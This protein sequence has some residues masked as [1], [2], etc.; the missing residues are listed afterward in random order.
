[1]K[2]VTNKSEVLIYP[3]LGSRE[4]QTAIM[5][6]ITVCASGLLKVDGFDKMTMSADNALKLA[7]A[8]LHAA[9]MAQ[10]GPK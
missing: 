9:E 10:N 3:F 2:V 1:M 7:E 5:G 8:L 6:C 4:R